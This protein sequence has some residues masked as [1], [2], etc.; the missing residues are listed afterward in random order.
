MY[1]HSTHVSGENWASMST[2]FPDIQ[3]K[4]FPKDVLDAMKAA[5]K[6][7]VEESAAADPFAA[8]VLNSQQ[9]YLAQVRQWTKMSD[10]AYL[11]STDNTK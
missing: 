4:T 5:N 11:I 6:K 1:A 10:L 3:V 2:E 8:K 9:R 7:L